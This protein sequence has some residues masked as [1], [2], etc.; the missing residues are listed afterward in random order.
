MNQFDSNE[1]NLNYLKYSTYHKKSNINFNKPIRPSC[2]QEL[3]AISLLQTNN[4][5]FQTQSNKV[6][7][8]LLVISLLV[9]G[10]NY[11]SQLGTVL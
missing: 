8:N 3:L 7:Q 10:D 4:L 11:F 6:I 1:Q 2:N 5:K 9:R